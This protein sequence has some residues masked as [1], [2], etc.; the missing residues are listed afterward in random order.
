[1]GIGTRVFI[2]VS[3]LLLIFGFILV[4][5]GNWGYDFWVIFGLVVFALSAVTGMAFLGRSRAASAS[6]SS[7]TASSIPRCRHAS[8]RI[9]MLSRIEVALLIAVVFVMVVKPFA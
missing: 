7:S 8:K 2:P 6:W 3:I 1:M 9:L 4:S 5:E